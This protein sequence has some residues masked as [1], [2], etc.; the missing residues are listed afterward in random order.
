VQWESGVPGWDAIVVSHPFH[1]GAVKK[2]G[3]GSVSGELSSPKARLPGCGS[4]LRVGSLVSHPSD[5]NKDVA[6]AGHPSVEL[7][8]D[9]FV[10][11]DLEPCRAVDASI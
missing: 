2:M 6:R 7:P 4:A 8:E 11:L 3:H 9:A 1:H 5:K 10:T